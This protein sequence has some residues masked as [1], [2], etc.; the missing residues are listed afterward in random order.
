[1]LLQ[2]DFFF[3]AHYALYLC[4]NTNIIKTNQYYKYFTKLYN[5]VVQQKINKNVTYKFKKVAINFNLFKKK[6]QCF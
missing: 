6:K 3:M 5:I 1:M 4:K 2:A